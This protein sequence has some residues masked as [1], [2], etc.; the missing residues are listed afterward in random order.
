MKFPGQPIRTNLLTDKAISVKFHNY[1]F[2]LGNNKLNYMVIV[3]IQKNIIII[4]RLMMLMNN[5][6]KEFKP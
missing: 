3:N 1:C 5:Q 2:L 6:P 4:V